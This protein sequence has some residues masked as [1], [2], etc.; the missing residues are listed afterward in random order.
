MATVA[1][2]AAL[3]GCVGDDPV[4]TG[5]SGGSTSSSGGTAGANLLDN[6]GFEDACNGWN[7]SSG[8]LTSEPTFHLGAKSCKAL[9]SN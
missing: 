6:S 5:S 7:S 1:V 2:L 4:L 8:D 3:T 9:I